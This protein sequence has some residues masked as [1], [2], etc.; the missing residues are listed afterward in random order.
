MIGS[1]C[2]PDEGHARWSQ[3]MVQCRPQVGQGALVPLQ[4]QGTGLELQVP[5]L[6]APLN[7]K[8]REPLQLG[9]VHPM[10]KG[11]V[12]VITVPLKGLDQ[13]PEQLLTLLV[14]EMEDIPEGIHNRI[15]PAQS[16]QISLPV[17]APALR[18]QLLCG[19]GEGG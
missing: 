16:V 7:R 8:H 14:P 11:L 4:S 3:F 9:E 18:H 10:E 13:L 19:A 15:H 1:P 6:N 17:S 2:D 12:E 5:T